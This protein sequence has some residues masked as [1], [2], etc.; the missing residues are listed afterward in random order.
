MSRRRKTV[1][2]EALGVGAGEDQ[3]SLGVGVGV[4]SRRSSRRRQSDHPTH[5]SITPH[6]TLSHTP[7]TLDAD[8][9]V[10]LPTS[11]YQPDSLFN[12]N[13]L[14]PANR[15]LESVK[16]RRE[17]SESVGYIFEGNGQVQSSLIQGNKSWVELY[18]ENCA[19]YSVQPDPGVIIALKTKWHVLHPT[20]LFSEG[21][22]LPLLGILEKN[23]HISQLNLSCT[24]MQDK[25]FASAGNGNTN[26]RV[27]NFIL[28]N[29][30]VIQELDLSNTGLDDN[31]LAEI[32]AALK[33]NKSLKR[34]NLASNFFTRIGAMSL[35]DAL[36][37]NTSLTFLDLSQNALGFQSINALQCSC[38]ARGLEIATMGNYVFE[39]IMN[40]V[41]HGLGFLLSIIG[42]VILMS[43]AADTYST[44]YHF[45]A[46]LLF[47]FTLLFLF[48]CS[49]LFHSFFMLPSASY[50]L[51]I[52]DHVAIYMLI[53]GSYTPFLLL[54][55]HNH[56]PAY[57]LLIAEWI[58]AVG[59]AVFSACSDLN[60]PVTNTIE[61]YLFLAMGGGVFLV[62]KT[63]L[64][65]LPFAS[66][67]LLALGG[68]GYL[69]G[70]IFFKLGQTTPIYHVV[71]HVFV[72]IGAGLHWFDVYFFMANTKLG[73]VMDDC[74]THGMEDLS[75]CIATQGA[76]NI[77]ACLS[78]A[79]LENLRR[80]S[81][82]MN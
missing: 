61:L 30:D 73:G 44:D 58:V 59:G 49:A 28:R 39:E 75:R 67:V 43:E 33:E 38:S 46:C 68:A 19:K 77:A 27:L 52:L 34:L 6:D 62:W 71:W 26:A 37:Q 81:N 50:V 3:Q 66:I 60:S 25:R 51:Q 21:A 63:L 35:M 11:L 79:S 72:M 78:A 64:E 13:Q 80:C 8:A 31:G 18:L 20:K 12:G 57:V 32:C 40:S 76:E 4:G 54:G 23:N 69:I 56:T 16:E 82:A 47:S 53:A 45:W 10:G 9:T 41:T 22:M 2:S 29:N 15:E 14:I 5:T 42:T 1:E 7:H 65:A 48:M 17:S 55:M 36:S 70:I 74:L 24:A